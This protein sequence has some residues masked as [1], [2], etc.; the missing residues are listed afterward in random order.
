M[1]TIIKEKAP[2]PTPE[3]VT[4]ELEFELDDKDTKILPPRPQYRKGKHE[5]EHFD[6]FVDMVR[7]LSINMPLL[8]ALQVILATSK[9]SWETSA[10]YRQALSS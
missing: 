8:D 7:R 10:R 5:D 9:T 4:E 6:K 3:I 2:T 1:E